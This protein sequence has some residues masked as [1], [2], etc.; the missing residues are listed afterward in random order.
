MHK[1]NEALEVAQRGLAA[2]RAFEHAEKLLVTASVLERSLIEMESAKKRLQGEIDAALAE[3]KQLDID[4]ADAM[5]LASARIKDS[6]VQVVQAEAVRD[7]AI[8]AAQTVADNARKSMAA[9]VAAFRAKCEAEMAALGKE[10]AALRDERDALQRAI[11]ELKRLV[12][13]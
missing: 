10:V 12:A 6:E 5:A 8:A 1:F 13:R 9:E 2:Y 3:R 11:A 7:D 4:M